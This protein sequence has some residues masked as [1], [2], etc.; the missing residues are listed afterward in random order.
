[1]T[2]F[3]VAAVS[4]VRLFRKCRYCCTSTVELGSFASTDSIQPRRLE[5]HLLDR[6]LGQQFLGLCHVLVTHHVA[7]VQGIGRDRP[8]NLGR[9]LIPFVEMGL[10]VLEVRLGLVDHFLRH[11]VA[12]CLGESQRVGDV[13]R[14]ERIFVTLLVAFPQAKAAVASLPRLQYLDVAG[15]ISFEFLWPSAF[16]LP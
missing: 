8:T 1:M 7:D 13:D 4:V 16:P 10:D 5:R 15:E 9:I 6:C 14:Q 3:A 11:L 12:L 2:K